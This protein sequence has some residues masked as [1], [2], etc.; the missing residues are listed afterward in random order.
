MI[1]KVDH[2]AV[3]V[4]SLDEAVE[5]FERTLGLRV[6]HRE[7]AAGFDVETATFDL[8]DV[9]LELVE[10]TSEAS[11]VRKFIKARGPGLHHIAFA[12]DDIERSLASLKAKGVRLIDETPRP[13]QA[14]SRVAF[15]HPE[16]T[17]KVLI[18]LVEL[19][20]KA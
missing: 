18:E 7:S 2:I 11:E 20:R 15:I 13:G 4:E 9:A 1:K 8:G 5:L 17:H 19:E 10:G 12:V 3:A 14:G 6:T 16:S